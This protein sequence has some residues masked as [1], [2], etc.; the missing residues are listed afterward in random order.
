[1]AQAAVD[2]PARPAAVRGADAAADSRRGAGA[3][4]SLRVESDHVFDAAPRPRLVLAL[5]CLGL[6]LGCAALLIALTGGSRVMVSGI[7]LSA[8][9]SATTAPPAVRRGR[10]PPGAG[11]TAALPALAAGGLAASVV[12]RLSPSTPIRRGRQSI[13]W[14]GVPPAASGCARW[15]W[16]CCG[17]SCGTWTPCRTSAIRSCRCGAPAGCWSSCAAILAAVLRRQ[18]LL[19]RAADVHVLRLDAAAGA[20]RG[21]GAGGR[22]V[23][24]LAYNLL[25]ISGFV[26]L[27]DCGGGPGRAPHRIVPGRVR[28]R[29]RSSASTRITSSTTATSSCR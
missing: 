20:D 11:P 29:R 25:L 24:G 18:Y 1:M 19:P 10:D 2:R 27:G 3:G 23:P 4:P 21:A 17:R 15:R 7:R 16:C 12:P 14:R 5:D 28:R 22:D 6:I 8:E 9:R 26:L 13:P